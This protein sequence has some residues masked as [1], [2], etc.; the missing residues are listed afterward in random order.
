MAATDAGRLLSSLWCSDGFGNCWKTILASLSRL[1]L[2]IHFTFLKLFIKPDSLLLE[3]KGGQTSSEGHNQTSAL[4]LFC[5][6]DPMSL[7]DRWKNK[8]PGF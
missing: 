3:D 8:S 5:D 2:L 7:N 4:P 1:D 6:L